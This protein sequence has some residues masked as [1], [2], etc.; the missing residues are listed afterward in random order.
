MATGA[1]L[2]ACALLGK[3]EEASSLHLICAVNVSLLC[4]RCTRW[5]CRGSVTAHLYDTL[6]QLVVG[7]S[8]LLVIMSQVEVG[9]ID[10][11]CNNDRCL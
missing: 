10:S 4:S 5:I 3:S 7:A 8:G 9:Y 6:C 2:L 11:H 1:L